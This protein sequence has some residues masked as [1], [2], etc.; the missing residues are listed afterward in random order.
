MR[1]AIAAVAALLLVFL[2]TSSVALVALAGAPLDPGVRT[3]SL[4]SAPTGP[5]PPAR[6]PPV[7]VP[8]IE[9]AARICPAVTPA[10]LAAQ[11]H[12]ESGFRS[13]AVSTAGA[14]GV[15]QFMPGTW[16]TWGADRDG[17]GAADPFD[18]A[19]AIPADARALCSMVGMATR[20]GLDGPPVALALAGYNAG[21]GAVLRYR[22]IP[23]YPQTRQ[24]VRA[25]LAAVA[26][27]AS[28]T[29]PTVSTPADLAPA[30]T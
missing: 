22:G 6:V 19:D 21:W 10:L 27:F 2:A 18:P 30:G 28:A 11:L 5:A 26:S 25:I 7:L 15:A 1:P 12:Q 9:A 29:A 16:R 14:Q 23:P 3:T 4:A 8:V 20:A 24:Y 17:V 13:D